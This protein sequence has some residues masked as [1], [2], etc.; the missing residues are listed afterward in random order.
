MQGTLSFRLELL[1]S[2]TNA[3]KSRYDWI[4]L[5][6]SVHSFKS[7]TLSPFLKWSFSLYAPNTSVECHAWFH[8]NAASPAARNSEQVNITKISFIVVFEPSYGKET[9]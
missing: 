2:I 3:A 7:F 1:T 9:S 5:K 4:R 6:A 8:V